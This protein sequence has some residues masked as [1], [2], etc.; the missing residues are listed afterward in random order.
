MLPPPSGLQLYLSER[1]EHRRS[2]E[3]LADFWIA[4]LL[5]ARTSGNSTAAD[6][7]ISKL[8][9]FERAGHSFSSREKDLIHAHS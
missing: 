4:G 1:H 7:A 3:D 5:S 9:D 2:S 8:K 6:Q